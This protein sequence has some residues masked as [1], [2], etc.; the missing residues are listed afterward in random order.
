MKAIIPAILIAATAAG[1]AY[2][3]QASSAEGAAAPAEQFMSLHDAILSNTSAL[4][5]VLS[6]VKDTATAES[7]AARLKP[8]LAQRTA[9]Q[10][11]EGNMS[12]GSLAVVDRVMDYYDERSREEDKAMEALY[13]AYAAAA[14]HAKSSGKL[15]AALAKI[16]D[17][18]P[19]PEAME[20]SEPITNPVPY[21]QYVALL[22]KQRTAF[23]QMAAVLRG[24]K[25][26]ADADA[27]APALQQWFDARLARDR[28][29]EALGEPSPKVMEKL[30][31]YYDSNHAA[32]DAAAATLGKM[33]RPHLAAKAP[34]ASS[35]ALR[36]VAARIAAQYATAL[37]LATPTRTAPPAPERE[38]A[39]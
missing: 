5:A 26:A 33:L 19:P 21:E 10:Q 2:A 24:V 36:A 23:Q 35:E 7:A 20:K 17:I 27:A 39:P 3:K 31:L 28:E 8:L 29:L 32:D 11:A 22:E 9:L 6:E 30:L 38:Q 12:F 13:R 37:G 15:A 18:A 16:A 14:P 25:S 34:S 4:A 1:G